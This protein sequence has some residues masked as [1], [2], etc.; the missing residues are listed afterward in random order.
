LQ[1]PKRG[2]PK[3]WN[4]ISDFAPLPVQTLAI[5]SPLTVLYKEDCIENR[6]DTEPGHSDM[7]LQT[8]SGH[9]LSRD[10]QKKN[11]YNFLGTTFYA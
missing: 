9:R 3:R 5:E 2:A 8:Y 7:T 1:A 6:D 10:V 11:L 4:S